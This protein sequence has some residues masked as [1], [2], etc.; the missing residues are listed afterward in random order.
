MSKA[1]DIDIHETQVLEPET[2]IN[3]TPTQISLIDI[4]DR[5]RR[6]STDKRK[7]SC[8]YL[9][10]QE[11][12]NLFSDLEPKLSDDDLVKYYEIWKHTPAGVLYEESRK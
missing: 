9:S 8:E 7:P 10:L 5:Y 6:L 3:M 2:K 4:A 12:R 1:P 11:L